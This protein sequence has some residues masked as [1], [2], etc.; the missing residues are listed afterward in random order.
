MYPDEDKVKNQ[1]LIKLTDYL[2]NVVSHRDV[3]EYY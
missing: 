3:R 1:M 2:D